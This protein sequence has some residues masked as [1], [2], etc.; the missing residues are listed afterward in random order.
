SEQVFNRL[1]DADG[2]WVG[3]SVGYRTSDRVEL[4]INDRVRT[5]TVR[6]VYP[7]SN[8]NES[9]I[10]MDLA[11][12]QHALGRYGRVDRILLKVPETPSLGDWQ[13]RL[14]T[15]LPAGV[16]VRLRGT[17]TNENRRMLAAFRWNLRLL[18][19]ISLI[20]GAFLIYNTISVSVVRRR[21]E[22]GRSEEHTSELQSRFDLVCRLLLATS[23][24]GTYTL[25][26]HDALPISDR[27]SCRSG[28]SIARHCH[29]RE[30]PHACRFPLELAPLE[31]H[32]SHCRRIPDLQ[33]HLRLGR[34]PPP[35]DW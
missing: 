19:Y 3:S 27:A 12:A 35:G 29:E 10:V 33:H 7:D 34:P 23:T 20:V 17:A 14:R 26:L 22:I 15:V 21:P 2:I 1:G 31:L 6:G 11:A 24:T 32:F 25:S 30:S 18:S 5:Y 9:A 28:S 4:L 8:G 16:E 13:Q